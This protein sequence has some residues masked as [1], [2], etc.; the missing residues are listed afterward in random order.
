MFREQY[1]S[2]RFKKPY[3]SIRHGNGLP[4]TAEDILEREDLQR[5]RMYLL[6]KALHENNGVI[7]A[8]ITKS[9][10]NKSLYIDNLT[11]QYY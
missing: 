5:M 11:I 9:N 10:N 6:T 1:M 4:L 8:L 2:E 3:I 7:D